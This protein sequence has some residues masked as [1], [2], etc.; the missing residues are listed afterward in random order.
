MLLV[1]RLCRAYAFVCFWEW[2][3]IL[4]LN[5]INFLFF[6]GFDFDYLLR[7]RTNETHYLSLIFNNKKTQEV[8]LVGSVI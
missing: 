5:I 1:H 4:S 2:P 3:V 6:V 7:N 8:H